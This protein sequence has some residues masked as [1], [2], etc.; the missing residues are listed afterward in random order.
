MPK[1]AARV[2]AVQ[3]NGTPVWQSPDGQR[4]IWKV[5]V[6]VNGKTAECST[7]SQQLATVGFQGEIETYERTNNRGGSDTFIKQPPR[8][9][10][11]YNTGAPV[12]V[13]GVP[14]RTGYTPKD[15]TAI[16]AM[17]SIGQAVAFHVNEGET[18]L[19][20]IEKT[21]EE[22]FA[23]VDRVKKGKLAD[24]PP[25]VTDAFGTGEML[26]EDGSAPWPTPAQNN[27]PL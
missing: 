18:V 6:D 10:S 26:G 8:E 23:M 13:A 15:E 16:K 20:A 5:T 11:Q 4:K 14:A 1:F 19:A 12:G 2:V 22:L 21:A 17:W 27:L 3:N 7:Y 25:A 9:D 24:V